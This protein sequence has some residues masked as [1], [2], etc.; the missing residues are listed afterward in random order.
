MIS[1]VLYSTCW[2]IAPCVLKTLYVCKMAKDMT[3]SVLILYCN[4]NKNPTCDL[5]EHFVMCVS[6]ISERGDL[7]FNKANTFFGN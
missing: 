3:S 4:I 2:S 1:F 5:D 6:T 7:V